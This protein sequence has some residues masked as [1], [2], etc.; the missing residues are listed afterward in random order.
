M[1]TVS[2]TGELYDDGDFGD[3]GPPQSESH[4]NDCGLVGTQLFGSSTKPLAMKFDVLSFTELS[5]SKYR[6]GLK[7]SSVK[8]ILLKG[9]IGDSRAEPSPQPEKNCCSSY[10]NT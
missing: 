9:F 5:F 10:N 3:I 4:K 8:G 7:Y 6:G 2:N 1:P